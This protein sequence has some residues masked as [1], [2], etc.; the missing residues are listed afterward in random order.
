MYKVFINTNLLVFSRNIP[1]FIEGYPRPA[2][3][4]YSNKEKLLQLIQHFETK[5][6]GFQCV[7]I[8]GMDEHK[9]WKQFRQ[10]YDMIEAG[11]GLVRNDE[12]RILFIFRN[13]RWDLPKGKLDDG[14]TPDAGAIREVKEECGISDLSILTF[15]HES[16]HTYGSNGRRKLKRTSW[17]RMHSNDQKLIPQKE[18]GITH[19]KWMKEK[20][21]HKVLLNTYPGIIEVLSKDIRHPGWAAMREW[22]PMIGFE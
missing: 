7:V 10:F 3:I 4:L 21:L 2:P 22:H 9:M 16:Y 1:T 12:G 5:T 15:L 13:G 14:E 18:E 11:G 8:Y 19:I 17:F 20:K 6:D